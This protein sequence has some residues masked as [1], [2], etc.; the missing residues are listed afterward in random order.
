[1][2]NVYQFVTILEKDSRRK[3]KIR[4]NVMSLDKIHNLFT[5]YF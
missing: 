4:Q 1:M 5:K 3:Q 2:Q